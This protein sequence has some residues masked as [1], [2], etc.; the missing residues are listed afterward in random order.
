LGGVGEGVDVVFEAD[1]G[2]DCGGEG[3]V[4]EAFVRDGEDDE[5]RGE[6]E[7]DDEETVEVVGVCAE[8]MEEG[9]GKGGDCRR[10]MI[11]K[12][13]RLL[14]KGERTEDEP[15]NKLVA[16]WQPFLGLNGGDTGPRDDHGQHDQSD[17]RPE[18]GPRERIA[19]CC[20]G[21]TPTRRGQKR[22]LEKEIKDAH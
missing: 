6:G 21:A 1:P 13:L 22:S 16:C 10:L 17:L 18:D 4:E 2:D 20:C 15:S 5:D 14:K 12:A 9:N 11:E 19:C 3:E 8:A 7:E